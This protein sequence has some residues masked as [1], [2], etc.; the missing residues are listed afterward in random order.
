V[1]SL[2]ITH[3]GIADHIGQ[4]QIAPYLLGVA[5]LG[6][7]I[8]LL[9]LEKPGK[10]EIIA[11]YQ[12][13]FDEAGIKWT[14]LRYHR[15]PPIA[16]Q[17]FDTLRLRQ[18]AV[19]IAKRERPQI[20][21]CR[22]YLPIE[23]GVAV[24]RATGAKLLIDF[25]HFYNEGGMKNSRFPFAFRALKKREPYYF[26]HAD[27]VVALTRKATVILDQWYPSAEGL[28]RFSVIPC[29]ADFGMFDP[30]RVHLSQAR[31]ARKRLAIGDEDFVL[32]YLGSIGPEYL[33]DEMFDVFSELLKRRP[34]ARFLFLCNNGAEAVYDAA[35]RKGV[36]A[37]KVIVTSV[38][39]DEVPHYLAISSLSVMFFQPGLALA[40]CFPTKLSE[41]FAFN[42]PVIANSGVG[43]LEE[44][45]TIK[46]NCSVAVDE[47]TPEVLGAA[48]DNVLECS[49]SHGTAI[50]ENSRA[51]D[52]PSGIAAYDRIYRKLGS[53]PLPTGQAVG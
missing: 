14:R 17:L 41:V 47:F 15:S 39:R 4:S 48:I 42:I 10:D 9:S 7:Q 53:S 44:L 37:D 49:R 40:G 1:K 28:G 12:A 21:H 36:P 6:H 45:L 38:P 46:A 29:C 23:A 13:A 32:L 25:R 2:Y 19:A 35:R 51:F 8:H 33:V 16:A 27:H 43:D 26:R 3:N 30:S 22:S 20:V 24:K 50:R 52:L 18:A 31:A 5:G 11:K 34:N